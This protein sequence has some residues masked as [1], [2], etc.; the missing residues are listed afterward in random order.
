MVGPISTFVENLTEADKV[1]KTHHRLV[2]WVWLGE[3]D[4]ARLD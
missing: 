3:L 4:K 1:S 2:R